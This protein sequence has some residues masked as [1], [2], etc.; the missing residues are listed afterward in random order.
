MSKVISEERMDRALEMYKNGYKIND[1]VHATGISRATISRQVSINGLTR[2][3]DQSPAGISQEKINRMKQLRDQGLSN[4]LIAKEVGVSRDTVLKYLGRQKDMA[5]SPYGSVVSYTADIVRAETKPEKPK[6]KSSLVLDE[7]VKT[8][9]G[10][11][12]VY[13]TGMND[14]VR[15]LD[16]TA[17]P[18]NIDM[19]IAELECFISELI[20]LYSLASAIEG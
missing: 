4:A 9:H 15:I 19:S 10:K 6:P 7:C 18:V 1:I 16:H 8:Y 13:K 2:Y 17:A 20:D 3:P 12:F 14:H 11:R 5:R